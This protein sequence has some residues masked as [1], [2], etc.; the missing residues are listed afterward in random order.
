MASS[1]CE[2]PKPFIKLGSDS[3]API[4]DYNLPQ[5][6][7]YDLNYHFALNVPNS[8]FKESCFSVPANN[9]Y[10]K[11]KG[12]SIQNIINLLKEDILLGRFSCFFNGH[13]LNRYK[14]AIKIIVS[15]PKVTDN[16]LA[17]RPVYDVATSASVSPV[18]NI[19]SFIANGGNE[20]RGPRAGAPM[21]GRKASMESLK[22]LAVNLAPDKANFGVVGNMDRPVRIDHR[23][24]V[25]HLR[26]Q[27]IQVAGYTLEYLA[28]QIANGYLLVLKEDLN[29]KLKITFI[30]RPETPKPVIKIIEHH[31]L[32]SYLGNYGAGKVVKTFSLFPGEVTQITVRSYKDD[33]KSYYRDSQVT[34]NDMTSSFYEDDQTSV[35]TKSDNV[36]DSFSEYAADSLQKQVE[37][38]QSSLNV[39][40]FSTSDETVKNEGKGSS[41]S[42]NFF[43]VFSK[44]SGGGSSSSTNSSTT[45]SAMRE[46][47]TSNLTAS[48]ES[49]VSESSSNREVEVN[50]TSANSR[51]KTYGGNDMSQTTTSVSEGTQQV[52]TSGE[53]ATTTRYLRNINYSRTLN[54]VFRQMLQEYISISYL[55][56]ASF[57]YTNGYPDVEMVGSI[58]NMEDFLKEIIKP[59][60]INDVKKSIRL[61]FCNVID[62]LGDK[63]PFIEKVTETWNDCDSGT[64]DETYEY[65]RKR[66]NLE[67]NYTSGPVNVTVNGIIMSVS[68][69]TL[70][71][72]S[73]IVDAL[74]GQGDALDCYNIR[75]QEEAVRRSELENDRYEQDGQDDHAKITNA[76]AILANMTD[77]DAKAE[78]FRKMFNDC[79][80][81]D[82]KLLM[83]SVCNHTTPPPT[84]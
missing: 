83:G 36:L 23:S 37:D 58:I 42:V 80:L 44:S 48:L 56:D 46:D 43:G 65:W 28:T 75:S 82:I 55:N 76:L 14:D 26:E 17:G 10:D 49:H 45:S 27:E 25:P 78:A 22:E 40:T 9:V 74:L 39:N 71:T 69:N 19:G 33:K 59:E 67:Q 61:H 3:N 72:D 62:Y 81:E 68:K 66:R 4:L 15:P 79:C 24:S 34:T 30:K 47:M 21:A 60:H 31:K 6:A 8:F 70:R 18:V 12:Q 54:L 38:R 11:M 73:L 29:G 84:A 41:K 51:N 50:T 7:C 5:E 35:H 13:L 1:A 32:C 53:E 16:V 20:V 64:P 52:I 63:V 57:H 2:T 77:P